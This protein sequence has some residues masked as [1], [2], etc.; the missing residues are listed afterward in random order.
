VTTL[1]AW[2]GLVAQPITPSI[3]APDEIVLRYL[4]AFGP[5]TMADIRTWSWLSG[6]RL[7]VERL[8]PRLRTYRD[9][10]GREL[11]DV[12]DG[13]FAEASAAARVR[14]LG[15]YDNVFLSHADR[16]RMT[17]DTPWGIAFVRKGAFFVDGFL[18]GSWSITRTGDRASMTIEPRVPLDASH[19]E[20]EA[21]AQALLG[22]LAPDAAS[23]GVVF[24]AQ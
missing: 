11:L 9:E 2:L 12:V 18:A 3:A 6:L 21:E 19:R 5:A 1:A 15:E 16:S 7:V 8:R 10:A 22:F 4:R 20:V 13:V 24:A 14:F 17:G 23:S